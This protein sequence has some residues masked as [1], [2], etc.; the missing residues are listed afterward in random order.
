MAKKFIDHRDIN[1]PGAWLIENELVQG[2]PD[3]P[4]NRTLFIQQFTDEA[5]DEPEFVKDCKTI[6]DVFAQFKP[7]KAV[8]F[9]DENGAPV[10]E[11]EPLQFNSLIDFGKQGIIGQSDFLKDLKKTQETYAEFIKRLRSVKLLRNVMADP[12][13]KEAY[14]QALDQFIEELESVDPAPK[15]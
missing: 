3:I 2:T 15:D 1:W 6:D 8:Q 5:P 4:F 14:L 13:L 12:A 7:N 9:E 11:D 10:D